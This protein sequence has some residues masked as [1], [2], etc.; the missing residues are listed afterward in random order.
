MAN[1]KNMESVVVTF[2]GSPDENGAP[3]IRLGRVIGIQSEYPVVGKF[4]IV[5]LDEPFSQE[6]PWCGVCVPEG[7]L[8]P[9][10]LQ[11]GEVPF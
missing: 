11:P 10:A 2:H 9:T 7:Q 8:A 6:Y 3:P 5:L 4:Y 1:Y